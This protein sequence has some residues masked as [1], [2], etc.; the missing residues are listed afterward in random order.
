MT[1]FVNSI[2]DYRRIDTLPLDAMLRIPGDFTNLAKVMDTESGSKG[3]VLDLL[4][5]LERRIIDNQELIADE[6]QRRAMI[7][8]CKR[9]SQNDSCGVDERFL[10]TLRG[11]E[12]DELVE[13]LRPKEH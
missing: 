12:Y 9:D 5:T 4:H 3:T 7:Q 6:W 8:M 10:S 1:P 13:L 11:M 2:A